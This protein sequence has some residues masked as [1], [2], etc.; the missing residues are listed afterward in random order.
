MSLFNFDIFD[1]HRTLSHELSE[2]GRYLFDRRTDGTVIETSIEDLADAIDVSLETDE[3]MA[4]YGIHTEK[5]ASDFVSEVFG[6]LYEDSPEMN[7]SEWCHVQNALAELPEYQHLTSSVRKDADLSAMAASHVVD[8]FR[9]EVVDIL[10]KARQHQDQK[11]PEG[12]GPPGQPGQ[13]GPGPGQPK[14]G[15]G[16]DQPGEG[17]DKPDGEQPN[18]DSG[19]PEPFELDKKMKERLMAKAIDLEKITENMKDMKGTVASIGSMGG[20]VK[21]TNED[22]S[23]LVKNLMNNCG[24]KSLF[25]MMGRLKSLMNSLP[26]YEFNEEQR[27]QVVTVGRGTYTDLL[28]SEQM[29]LADDF[30]TDIFLDR[31]IRRSQHRWRKRGKTKVGSGPIILLLDESSSMS[32]SRNTMA[33]AFAGALATLCYDEGRDFY[34]VGFN[35]YITHESK[36]TKNSGCHFNNRKAKPLDVLHSI[37]QRGC[38]GGTSFD[39][40]LRKA[41]ELSS[42]SKKAD[43]ILL[44]DGAAH[45]SDSVL[46]RLVKQ[47]KDCGLRMFT[48][49]VAGSQ[50]NAVSKMSDGVA[51]VSDLNDTVS[52][53]NLAKI[54]KQSLRR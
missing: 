32:G 31:W 22:R 47:K 52:L 43:I 42:D 37:I 25:K 34:S 2:F 1:K 53:S 5:D 33:S 14:P 54:M 35:R 12:D 20:E 50:R 9:D 4:K 41:I 26:A 28:Q 48:V 13:P 39:R 10:Q 6:R 23:E 16:Q 36:I 45:I 7:E 46:E 3:D 30:T 19:Q 44:T 18:P 49:L 15:T 24:L 51:H 40:P 8:L 38:S 27:E 11:P 29:L 21:G 17:G